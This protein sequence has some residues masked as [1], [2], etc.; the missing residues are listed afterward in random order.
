[1]I[2]WARRTA[3]KNVCKCMALAAMHL[4]NKSWLIPPCWL[5]VMGYNKLKIS[6]I[7]VLFIILMKLG[8][9]QADI[10]I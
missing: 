10:I 3:H 1:M 5:K 4:H 9:F 7:L 8:T 6:V 2:G